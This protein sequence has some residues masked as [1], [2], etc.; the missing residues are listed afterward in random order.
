VK[1]RQ[2]SWL[3]ARAFTWQGRESTKHRLCEKLGGYTPVGCQLYLK[4]HDCRSV[5]R[6][7]HQEQR[8]SRAQDFMKKTILL[9]INRKIVSL[10]SPGLSGQAA[11]G[12]DVVLR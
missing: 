5:H 7:P 4:R 12:F 6:A 3:A 1:N 9:S 2:N 11:V 8:H 10:K